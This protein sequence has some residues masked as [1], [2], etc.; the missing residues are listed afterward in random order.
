MYFLNILISTLAFLSDLGKAK[1]NCSFERHKI[2][3][4]DQMRIK[5]MNCV[6]NFIT[7]YEFLHIE[8]QNEPFFERLSEPGIEFHSPIY[9]FQCPGESDGSFYTILNPRHNYQAFEGKSI[10]FIEKRWNGKFNLGSE[11]QCSN[12]L[13]EKK[14]WI[15]QSNF[16]TPICLMLFNCHVE[17]T[18]TQ[19]F[20]DI[21]KEIIFYVN[22]SFNDSMIQNCIDKIGLKRKFLKFDEFDQQG[23]CVCDELTYYLNDCKEIKWDFT[24][25]INVIIFVIAFILM[26]IAIEIFNYLKK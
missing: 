6:V 19:G 4:R 26:M 17:K 9:M 8:S 25:L 16:D 18:D 22:K 23:W 11:N 14:I 13:I 24:P 20:Y 21:K 7:D 5:V 2:Y 10:K 1:T 3:E 15:S 12:N